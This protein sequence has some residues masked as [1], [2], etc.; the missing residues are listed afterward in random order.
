MKFSRELMKG[1]APFIILQALRW[2]KEAYG[3]QLMKTIREQS[4]ET[5]DFPD[6][7][8][9]PILYRL[10]EKGLVE[11]EIKQ[12]D[13]KKERRYYWLTEKGLEYLG[14]QEKEMKHYIKG[15]SR[16]MPGHTFA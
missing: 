7:T 14:V 10:E 2:L 4:Q 13:S 5:F 3:Y 12:L 6:S 16:F 9:Y 8:L 15:L 11:S 1:A